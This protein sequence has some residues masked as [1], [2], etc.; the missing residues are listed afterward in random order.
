M[1]NKEINKNLLQI[2]IKRQKESLLD[3]KKYQCEVCKKKI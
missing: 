3:W 2:K 1:E